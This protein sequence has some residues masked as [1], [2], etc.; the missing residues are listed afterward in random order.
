DQ[1]T[2]PICPQLPTFGD[3]PARLRHATLAPRQGELWGRESGSGPAGEAVPT[4]SI[5][6]HQASTF[7]NTRGQISHG[8]PAIAV[9]LA[10]STSGSP[11]PPRTHGREKRQNRQK[12]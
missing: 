1:L 5:A 10:T 7:L 12:G 8:H 11:G 4:A 6:R 9:I 3:W 2:A